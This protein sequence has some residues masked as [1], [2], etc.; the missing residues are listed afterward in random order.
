MDPVEFLQAGCIVWL[1]L[2][3]VAPI[4]TLTVSGYALTA[5]LALFLTGYC[6]GTKVSTVMSLTGLTLFGASFA[7]IET[8]GV[9]GA[10]GIWSLGLLMWF[11]ALMYRI[12]KG[13][14][15]LLNMDTLLVA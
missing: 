9:W 10:Q 7:L 13:E 11:G 12:R 3:F 14:R 2:I 8:L 6:F 15:D 5:L 1:S 4:V